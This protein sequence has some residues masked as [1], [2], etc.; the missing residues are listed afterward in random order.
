[1]G[2][3]AG[4]R[5][6]AGRARRVAA[7]AG[8]AEGGWHLRADRRRASLAGGAD[9]GPAN[10]PGAVATARGRRRVG[11]GADREHGARGPEPDRGGARVRGADR[12]ARPY[13]RG[14]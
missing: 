13:A 11:A 10:D 6:V 2:G 4:A 14:G 7:G 5:R 8:A 12:G 1:P 3:A 9:G